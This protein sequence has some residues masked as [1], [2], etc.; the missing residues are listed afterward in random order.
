MSVIGVLGLCVI[1]CAAG[2]FIGL[3]RLRDNLREPLEEVV[4]TQIAAQIAPN[5]GVTPEPGTYVIS[6]DD[7]NAGL[8]AE[9]DQTNTFDN[10]GVTLAPNGFTIRFETRNEGVTYS[11]NVTAVN[12][13]LKVIDLSGDGALTFFLPEKEVAKALENAVN[14]YLTANGL[15]LAS[16]KLGNGTL[17]LTTEAT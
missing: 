3:P 10:V 1:A 14:G 7:L 8:L 5:P 15:K 6:E 9:V 17:T 4:G 13:K 2:Y 11:G 16:A 12:G